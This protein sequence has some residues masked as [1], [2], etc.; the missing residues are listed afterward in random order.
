[1][2]GTF[3][4][5]GCGKQKQT[6]DEAV[7]ARNLYTSTYFDL[8][9]HYAETATQWAREAKQQRN[10]WAILS[11]EHVIVPPRHEIESYETAVEDLHTP[12]PDHRRNRDRPDG[13]PV[14]T[15]VDLWATRV[16][17]RLTAWLNWPFRSDNDSR[18]SPCKRL[19]VLA[20]ERYVAPLETR[21]A[22]RGNARKGQGY[23]LPA[24]PEFPFRT[25]DLSGIG[26]QMAWLKQEAKRL[27]TEA[28]PAKRV[29]L[30]G[31]GGGYERDRALWQL[32]RSPIDTEATEQ[33]SL[34]AFEDVAERY[35]ATEQR[36]L[37]DLVC[38]DG[39]EAE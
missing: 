31:F 22:F 29:E 9:R 30:S 4:L 3:V 15:L 18:D 17:S 16:A 26:E 19:I 6:T 28:A 35:V 21:G 37:D 12:A 8:K 27:E 2:K 5:V 39:G 14:E 32:D 36:G 1:M 13:E 11:A 10:A 23:G 25:E 20:G 38:A 24:K 7:E 33:T 34:D